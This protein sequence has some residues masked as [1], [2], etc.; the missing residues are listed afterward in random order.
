MTFTY[1]DAQQEA[2]RRRGFKSWYEMC[3]SQKENGTCY[4]VPSHEL[5][6]RIL[7]EEAVKADRERI[8]AKRMKVQYMKKDEFI[9]E[10]MP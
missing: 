4:V 7:A 1:K 3:Y 2:A 9:N 6:A 8:Y 5:A 10:P